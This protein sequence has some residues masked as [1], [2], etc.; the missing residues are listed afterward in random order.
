MAECGGLEN[1]WVAIPRGFESLALRSLTC[2]F[3]WFRVFVNRRHGSFLPQP[4]PNE[5]HGPVSEGARRAP[6]VAVMP[7]VAGLVGHARS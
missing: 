1:R 7:R 2:R 4:C 5:G 6:T 3:I